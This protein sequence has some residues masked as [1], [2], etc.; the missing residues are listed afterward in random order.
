MFLW[1]LMLGTYDILCQTRRK[2]CAAI[3]ACFH[4]FPSLKMG[5]H[6]AYTTLTHQRQVWAAQQTAA[7][8]DRIGH[9]RKKQPEICLHGENKNKINAQHQKP[10]QSYTGPVASWRRMAGWRSPGRELEKY[11]SVY[12]QPRSTTFFSS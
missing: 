7:E 5:Q 6:L 12:S 9:S 1:L 8:K 11:Q 4:C 3:R 2:H 10:G